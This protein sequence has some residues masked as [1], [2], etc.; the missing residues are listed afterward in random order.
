M[1]FLLKLNLT[2]GIDM[3]SKHQSL[4]IFS[5]DRKSIGSLAFLPTHTTFCPKFISLWLWTLMGTSRRKKIK[6]KIIDVYTT[7]FLFILKMSLKNY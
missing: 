2:E 4:A 5:S 7:L 1:A 6:R 3:P